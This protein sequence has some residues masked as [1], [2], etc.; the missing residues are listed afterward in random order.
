MGRMF[1]RKDF[2]GSYQGIKEAGMG[3]EVENLSCSVVPRELWCWFVPSAC[4]FRGVSSWREGPGL[5]T[6]AVTGCLLS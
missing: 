1:I 3:G 4:P 5:Y 2:F 6:W